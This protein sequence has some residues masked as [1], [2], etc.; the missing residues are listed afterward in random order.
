[1]KYEFFQTYDHTQ[2]GYRMYCQC[3]WESLTGSMIKIIEAF[4]E[5]KKYHEEE[6][7]VRGS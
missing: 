7:D 6:D 5:H 4:K 3:G 1:M 2:H